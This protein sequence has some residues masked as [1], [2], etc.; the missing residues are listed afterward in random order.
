MQPSMQ[1]HVHMQ[2][3]TFHMSSAHTLMHLKQFLYVVQMFK[4]DFLSVLQPSGL[5][6]THINNI[7]FE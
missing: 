1:T 5:Q 3:L 4:H 2:N 7:D 6:L